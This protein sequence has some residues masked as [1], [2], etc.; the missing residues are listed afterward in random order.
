MGSDYANCVVWNGMDLAKQ[1][2]VAFERVL[3]DN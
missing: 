2:V 1:R 3:P